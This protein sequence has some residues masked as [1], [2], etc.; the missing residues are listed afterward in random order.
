MKKTYYSYSRLWCYLRDPEE[1]Y[2]KYHLKLYDT[3]TPKMLLG[4]IFSDAYSKRERAETG[5]NFNWKLAL[6]YPKEYYRQVPPNLTFTS[7]YE[8]VMEKALNHPK[9]VIAPPKDC[10]QTLYTE[11]PICP[12]QAKNDAFRTSELLLIENKYG[13]PWNE[14]RVAEDD[15]LTFYSYVPW[16]LYKKIPKGI[17]QSI[18]ARTGEV[19]V[20]EFK[21]KKEDF[22]ALIEK[23][24]YAYEGIIA[25]EFS[26]DKAIIK[27]PSYYNK[28]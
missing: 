17:L 11:S 12:L 9:L 15:Q 10:E 3:P 13:A 1:Y 2:R 26:P 5:I 16:L 23:I 21:R 24:K 6:K 25:E 27:S 22:K 28:S 20:F 19:N 4:S 18:N 14:E 7:D 8:R